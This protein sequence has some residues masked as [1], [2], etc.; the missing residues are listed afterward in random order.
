MMSRFALCAAVVLPLV[1][2]AWG[3]DGHRRLAS[4]MQ[5]PLPAGHCLRAWYLAQQTAALQDKSC[6]PD[7]WRATD[8][9]EWP[10]HFLQIDQMSP[11]ASYP[12]DYVVVVRTLGDRSARLNGTVPWRVDALYQ[13]LVAA[14]AEQDVPRILDRSFVLSHYVF[15]AFSVLH[16]TRNS[17]PNNGLHAR[18]ESDMLSSASNLNAIASSAVGY[19]GTPG[20]ADPLYNTFDIIL[21]GNGL[22]P[23]L[24]QADLAAD[25]GIAGLFTR[26]RELTSRRW[27]DGLTLMA[28]IL[29]T[30]WAEAGAPDLPGF[31]ATCGREVPTAPAVLRGYP[32]PGGF[33]PRPPDGGVEEPDAGVDDA[34]A[35][36]G[37]GTGGGG[38]GGGVVPGG[39]AGGGSTEP[40]GCGC[41]ADAA[42]VAAWG[43][44]A[45]V[46]VRRP[47]RS[48]SK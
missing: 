2:Q 20:L 3:F 22:V 37:A 43:L 29:W 32:V 19:F 1:A 47:R 12:R 26:S 13:E 6:D 36:G 7:R 5:N 21:V 48:G 9:D 40:V 38:V 44:A 45:W 42:L 10:R 14:F 28:S 11:P 30:A 16:D 41:G 18:W 17:D 25:G 34:G 39:G 35:G 46:T 27:G 24:V 4:L 23:Q 15:D 33:T 8:A 31:S